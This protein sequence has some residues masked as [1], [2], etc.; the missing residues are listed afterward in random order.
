M[1]IKLLVIAVATATAT[2]LIAALPASAN[3]ICSNASIKKNLERSSKID[4]GFRTNM[5]LAH[6]VKRI[7]ESGFSNGRYIGGIFVM[8]CDKSKKGIGYDFRLYD[9]LD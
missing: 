4:Q 1:K 2:A 8:R 7:R 6:W 5:I 3:D 9:G